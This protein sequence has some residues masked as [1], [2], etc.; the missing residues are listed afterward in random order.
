MSLLVRG[1]HQVATPTGNTALRGSKLEAL[2]VR[3]GAV[4][5]CDRGEITFIGDEKEHNES[6]SQPDEILEADGGCVLPGFVDPHTHPVWA[7][8]RENEFDRRLRGET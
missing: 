6:F 3:S 1:A 5:R 8:S 2:D 4:V 7:G